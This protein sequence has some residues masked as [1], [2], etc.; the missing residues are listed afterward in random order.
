MQVNKYISTK[1]YIA[2]LLIFITSIAM[3][4][5]IDGT[6]HKLSFFEAIFL[7]IIIY[8][9]NTIMWSDWMYD[10]IIE[11]GGKID[12]IS[13]QKIGIFVYIFFIV[14]IL[15]TTFNYYTNKQIGLFLGISISVMI[16]F[17][18]ISIIKRISGEK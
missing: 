4:N 7:G 15:C 18:L 16:Y 9:L 10:Y 5:T 3:S 11:N 14:T 13:Y 8:I 1:K 12:Y 6:G 17:I 2:Y